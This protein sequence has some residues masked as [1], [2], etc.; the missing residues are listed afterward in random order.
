M[1]YFHDS[2]SVFEKSFHTIF[3]IKSSKKKTTNESTTKPKA[4]LW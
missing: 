4:R 2:S 3:H 1:I